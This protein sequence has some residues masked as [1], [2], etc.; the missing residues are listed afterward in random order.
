MIKSIVL[1]ACL[2]PA[3][4]LA[5][6]YDW[7]DKP[8]GNRRMEFRLFVPDS[9]PKVRAVIALVPGHNGDGRGMADDRGWQELAERTQSALLG[10]FMQGDQ[11]GAYYE[12]GK[13]SGKIFL[14]ALAKLG[15]QSGHPEIAEAPIALW[16]HSAG[17]QFNY[18]FAGWKPERTIAFVANKGAYYGDTARSGIRKVPALWILG[19]KDTEIRIRN[20][21]GK[22]ED[23][24]KAGALWAL[25][26]EPNEGHGVG[27]SRDLGRVFL[28]EVITARVDS[29][30][31]LQP[32]NPA[33]GWLGDL[34]AKTV[35]KNSAVDSGPRSLGWLPGE[36]T[37]KLWVEIIGGEFPAPAA[38]EGI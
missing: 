22:Y 24:R 2:L 20:I 16:G 28:E 26:P 5:A 11:G 31:K 17:G 36:R 29:G 4:A 19:E 27:R 30:G 23:G 37:A 12:A 14:E 15:K 25:V 32:L 10:C 35:S 38:A 1:A 18:N 7:Q 33:D 21:T 13:W 3:A 8:E 34:A 6:S 9:V